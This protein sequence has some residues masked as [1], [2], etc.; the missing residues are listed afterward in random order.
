MA[1]SGNPETKKAETYDIW[2]NT[3]TEIAD[4]PYHATL[5]SL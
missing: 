1:V 5:V 3:W 4:Y 2:T